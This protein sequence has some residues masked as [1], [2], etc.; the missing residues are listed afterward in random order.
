MRRAAFA[1]A[2]ALALWLPSLAAA[3]AR[4]QG[5]ADPGIKPNRMIDRAEVRVSRVEIQPGATRRVHAHNDVPFHLWVP[6]TGTLEITIGSDA[7]VAA[8]PG[9]AFFLKRGTPHGFRNVGTT[10]AAVLEV[11]V[12]DGAAT[13]DR[14]QRHDDLTALALGV[15]ALERE[16]GR[17]P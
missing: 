2:L 12:K 17:V 15:A 6:M 5:E 1:G 3:Q 10:P 9:Q 11:F 4:A 8:A 16:K 13:A 7:P 14:G